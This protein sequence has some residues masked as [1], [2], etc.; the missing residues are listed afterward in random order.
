MGIG[1]V[2]VEN[3]SMQIG[4]LLTLIAG[5]LYAVHIL[6]TQHLSD[7]VDGKAFTTFQFYGATILAFVL[8]F[9]FEDLS[10]I[11]DIQPTIFLQIFYLAFFATTITMLCQTLGQKYTNECYASL[12][13]SLESVFGVIFSIIFYHEVLTMKMLIGFT[14]IFVAIIIS[15]T[16]LSFLRRS[17]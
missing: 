10:I 17:S 2:I 15:Q 14:F 6:M 12:I 13:L 9:L 7:H 11:Q 8:A 4:D 1:L 5:F 3:L 16:Q